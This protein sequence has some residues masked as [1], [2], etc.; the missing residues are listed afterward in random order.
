MSCKY[1]KDLSD[2]G[3]CRIAGHWCTY[4]Q[5]IAC[6]YKV[7]TNYDRIKKMNIKEMAEFFATSKVFNFSHC[8]DEYKAEIFRRW[9]ES[10]AKK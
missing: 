6:K 2:S 5:Q 7:I 8:T 3:Y 9:L 1:I 10:E 4:E